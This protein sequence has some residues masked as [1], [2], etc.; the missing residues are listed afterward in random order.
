MG[1]VID[2][3]KI[4][5]ERR[6]QRVI[7]GIGD[8]YQQAGEVA[9]AYYQLMLAKPE[10]AIQRFP[11]FMEKARGVNPGIG[12]A[13]AGGPNHDWTAP[14]INIVGIIY[15]AQERNI[16]KNIL[17]QCMNFLDGINYLNSQ[18]NVALI[19][20]PWLAAD[21][22]ITRP[23]YWCG[24]KEYCDL[25]KENK[26]WQE[27][28]GKIETTRS[29]FWL[30]MAVT[31]PEH[32]SLD[33]RTQ[34]YKQYPTLMDRT[35]DAIAAMVAVYGGRKAERNGVPLETCINKRL[36]KHDPML[37]DDIR[38]KIEEEKWILLSE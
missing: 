34:F 21:I 20:D 3:E 9:S 36:V 7:N 32:A 37:H 33:I 4:F 26:T 27:F 2:A 10:E 18:R 6:V 8:M 13:M 25:I 23:L 24:Y 28:S 14:I 30:A 16:R 5:L 38:R 31:H 11:E 17:Q 29:D 22:V 12:E 15:S 1:D 19:N 35:E